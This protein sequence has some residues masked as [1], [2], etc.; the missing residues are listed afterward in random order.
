MTVYEYVVVEWKRN[1]DGEKIGGEVVKNDFV[2]ARDEK[3]A[4]AKAVAAFVPATAFVP[5]KADWD[6]LEVVLRPF[7][8]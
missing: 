4:I 1:D 7:R 3:T 5:E 8:Q 2:V 6:V